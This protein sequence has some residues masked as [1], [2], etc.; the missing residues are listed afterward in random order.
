MNQTLAMATVGFVNNIAA[1]I[2]HLLERAV[3]F[4]AGDDDV[5]LA[6]RVVSVG[7]NPD[8]RRCR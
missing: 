8:G 7:R 3:A 1:F 5:W 4:R 6:G 2:Q